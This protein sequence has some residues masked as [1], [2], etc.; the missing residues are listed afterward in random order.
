MQWK[1][2]PRAETPCAQ[3]SS[4]SNSPFKRYRRKTHLREA[5][6]DSSDQKYNLKKQFKHFF[7]MTG[8]KTLRRQSDIFNQIGSLCQR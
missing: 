2:R 1:I 6:T 5:E 8:S 7:T 3:V 4:W